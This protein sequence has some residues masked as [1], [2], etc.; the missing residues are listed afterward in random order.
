MRK[1]SL[2]II[3]L[4]SLLLF[5]SP[6]VNSFVPLRLPR[7]YQPARTARRQESA[8]QGGIYKGITRST[9]PHIRCAGT[10]LAPKGKVKVYFF[11]E[12]TT[13]LYLHLVHS[14]RAGSRLPSR[15]MLM[16]A[17]HRQRDFHDPI[18]QQCCKLHVITRLRIRS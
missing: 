6:S 14:Y 5:S 2:L 7:R 3:V 15:F 13:S 12:A 9:V 18:L 10:E 17:H 4:Q 11:P 16:L 1:A 8:Q